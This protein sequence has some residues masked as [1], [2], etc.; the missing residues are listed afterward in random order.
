MAKAKA[1]PDSRPFK[2]QIEV[3]LSSKE[4]NDLAKD[5]ARLIDQLDT[6][7]EK[8]KAVKKEWNA[9]IKALRMKITEL[10]KAVS[11]GHQLTTVT[12]EE[13]YDLKE[14]KAWVVY[15]GDEY[16][17]RD[18]DDYEVAQLKQKPLFP[19]HD[20]EAVDDEP[21]TEKAADIDPST[22]GNSGPLEAVQ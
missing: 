10:S 19:K 14:K 7:E 5:C 3:K 21:D 9:D 13:F 8:Y 1:K 16:N 2:G 18:L 11:R 12:A 22:L 15:K 20:K 4:I 6:T 17:H